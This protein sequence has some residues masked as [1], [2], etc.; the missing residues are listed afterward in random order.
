LF[1]AEGAAAPL[2]WVI[3]LNP[4]SYGVAGLRAALYWDSAG[5][6]GAPSFWPAMLVSVLFGVATFSLATA[7][8]LRRVGGAR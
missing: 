7:I 1:P 2:R 5:S 8:V 4:L 3:H 6:S